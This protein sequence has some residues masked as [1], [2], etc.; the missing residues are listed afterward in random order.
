MASE[1]DPI[2]LELRADLGKYRADLQSTTS[3]VQRLLGN[4]EK[5]AQ[6]LEAQMRKS[7]G[8]IG[9]SLRGLAGTLGTYFT[10]RELTGLIDSFT[11]LQNQLRV[12]G[13]EGEGLLRV[14]STLLD[15]STRYGV[16]IEE[17]ANLYG[18]SS[19]A[20]SELGASEAQLLQI[21]EASALELL[22]SWC[23]E[24]V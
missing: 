4:Q 19:Q 10:G 23:R 13:L 7:S 1:I 12:S 15:M 24:F 11:R 22:I 17:L 16:S 3:Q 6:R 2:I 9:A 21:T 5:S 8:A 18:K 14:Q 20:A